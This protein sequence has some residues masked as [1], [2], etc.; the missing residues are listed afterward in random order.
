MGGRAGD[1][2]PLRR[3]GPDTLVLKLRDAGMHQ[4]VPRV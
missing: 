1:E 4:A 3:R 2:D